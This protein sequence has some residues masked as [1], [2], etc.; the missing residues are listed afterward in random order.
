MRCRID[1]GADGVDVVIG[2][3]SLLRRLSHGKSIDIGREVVTFVREL[4]D[5]PIL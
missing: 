4:C 3:S 1:A 2:T 5:L